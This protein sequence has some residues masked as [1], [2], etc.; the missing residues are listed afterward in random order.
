MLAALTYVRYGS[1][2]TVSGRR[3]DV[4]EILL[5]G[6]NGLSKVGCHLYVVSVDESDPD[7]V[8]VY[9]M[10]E[11]KQHHAASLQLPATR[12]AIRA[13]MPMLTGEFSASET[14]GVGGLMGTDPT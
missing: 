13:A 10:W 8:W 9:E 6:V 12:E 5:S 2:R 3:D 1:M 7:V 11:S 4:V 14:S